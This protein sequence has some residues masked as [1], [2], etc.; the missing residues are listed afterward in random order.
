MMMKALSRHCLHQAFFPSFP[1]SANYLPAHPTVRVLGEVM[2][3]R[4]TKKKKNFQDL[5]ALQLVRVISRADVLPRSSG[6]SYDL[7]GINYFFI[8]KILDLA[9]EGVWY[10]VSL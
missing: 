5:L 7:K 4:K 1:L 3:M 8:C 2:K 6:E 10:W 9:L